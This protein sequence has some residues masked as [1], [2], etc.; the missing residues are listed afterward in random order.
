MKYR[1]RGHR[2]TGYRELFVGKNAKKFP[3][4]FCLPVRIL[5]AIIKQK[6]PDIKI[7]SYS[8]RAKD[9]ESI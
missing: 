1:F 9:I 4:I 5:K 7:A 6:H 3:I 8:K 2:N